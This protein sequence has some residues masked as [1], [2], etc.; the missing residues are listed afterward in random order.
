MDSTK[1]VA[2]QCS[3]TEGLSPN[4]G[5]KDIKSLKWVKCD[6]F[7]IFAITIWSIASFLII[8]IMVLSHMTAIKANIMQLHYFLLS[9]MLNKSSTVSFLPRSSIFIR[10]LLMQSGH[11]KSLL[12]AVLIIRYNRLGYNNAMGLPVSQFIQKNTIDFRR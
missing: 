4:Y 10:N 8:F 1:I 6:Y 3:D 9:T 2:R 7:K 5:Q 12:R 11:R